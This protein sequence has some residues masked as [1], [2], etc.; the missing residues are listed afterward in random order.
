VA[1]ASKIILSEPNLIPLR[2]PTTELDNMCTDMDGYVDPNNPMQCQVCN[3]RH[4]T[5]SHYILSNYN[6]TLPWASFINLPLSQ[7]ISKRS[8]L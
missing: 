8:I 3:A 5:G 6:W 4:S 1:H 2:V 7:P